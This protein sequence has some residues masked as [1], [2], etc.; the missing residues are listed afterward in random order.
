MQLRNA[1]ELTASLKINLYKLKSQQVTFYFAEVDKNGKP[2]GG[3]KGFGFN[4]KTNKNSITLNKD[5]LEDEF[6]VTNDIPGG[7]KA[8]KRLTD[9]SSGFAGDAG[10]VAAAQEIQR[11]GNSSSSTATGDST[12]IL[13]FA[14]AALGA[15]ALAVIALL[16]FRK[17]RR[18]RWGD[19]EK[20]WWLKQLSITRKTDIMGMT[21][22]LRRLCAPAVRNVSKKG[23]ESQ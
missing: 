11:T 1:N 12:P 2:V 8:E 4:V 3:A 16:L 7:S 20:N 14:L 5:N 13:P 22:A 10:A 17:A 9:P 6:I 15:L 21:T 18:G 23:R 19:R